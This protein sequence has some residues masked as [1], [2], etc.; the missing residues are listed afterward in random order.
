MKELQLQKNPGLDGLAV[1]FYRSMWEKIKHDF[2][3]LVTDRNI[4][5]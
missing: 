4:E 2:C 5:R 3:D 1:E